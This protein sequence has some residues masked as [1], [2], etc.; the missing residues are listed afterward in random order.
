[1]PARKKS[2]KINTILYTFK[3]F[4]GVIFPMVTFPYAS[5]VLGAE[6]IGKVTF[7]NSI[8]S[9]FILVAGLGILSYAIREGSKYRDDR[10]EFE[11]FASE[12]YTINIMAT[13]ISVLVFGVTVFYFEKLI[14]YQGILLILGLAIPLTTVGVE[15]IF[16]I[17]E[18]YLYITVRSLVVQLFSLVILFIFVRTPKDIYQYAIFYLFST[19]AANIFNLFY[20][21]KYC[22]LHLC[23][24]KEMVKHLKPILVIFASSVAS[25]IY[26]STDTT[27]LGIIHDDAT[28]GYYAAASK[29][30]SVLRVS[31]DAV[32][33][34]SF[35]RLSF[36]LGNQMQSEFD[37]LAKKIVHI[38]FLV[39]APLT[40]GVFFMAKEAIHI[41]NGTG[42]DPAI[43]TLQIL[44]IAMPYSVLA[45]VLTKIAFLP[46]KYEKDILIATIVGAV[47]NF[48]LNLYLIPILREKG[49]ALTTVLAEVLVLAIMIYRMNKFYKL[50]GW[51]KCLIQVLLASIPIAGVCYLI[52]MHIVSEILCTIVAVLLS[53]LI[54]VV[55]LF[56]LKNELVME[57]TEKIKKMVIK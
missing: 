24:N 22:S 40:V 13:F 48:F 53:G 27:L 41:L 37:R 57:Y 33:S 51:A 47:T 3:T 34:V 49:A 2:L 11:Q 42:F 35:A 20:A 8:V 25:T 5:R 54:Y 32:V 16:N 21:R 7:S 18:D 44:S 45:S 52:K 46:Y 19:V 50:R 1:M 14:N 9:Y 17:F 38:A 31:V 30:Y 29:I 39:L 43:I 26:V 36:Y 12:I 23:F 6:G 28:V 55:V 15:W 56:V 10:Q 4:M